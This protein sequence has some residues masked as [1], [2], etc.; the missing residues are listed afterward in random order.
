MSQPCPYCGI[1]VFVSELSTDPVDDAVC[2]SCVRVQAIA[3]QCRMEEWHAAEY[4]KHVQSSSTVD[5]TENTMTQIVTHEELEASG[6]FAWP[7]GYPVLYLGTD[8]AYL[9]FSCAQQSLGGEDATLTAMI[10][11]G[12][13]SDEA[14]IACDNCGEAID[15]TL[16][17]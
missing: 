14:D 4:A 11:E 9:C 13:Y 5:R 10:L 16:R 8:S 12:T 3:Q 15:L 2:A 17:N 6:P 1:R 7:G